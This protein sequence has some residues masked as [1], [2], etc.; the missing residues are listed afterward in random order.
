MVKTVIVVLPESK[1]PT[2]TQD[3]LG[4]QVLVAIVGLPVYL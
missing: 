4:Q 3:E 1:V 2:A